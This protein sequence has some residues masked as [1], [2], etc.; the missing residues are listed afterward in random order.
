[1]CHVFSISLGLSG[2]S[3]LIYDCIYLQ[4]GKISGR[5]RFHAGLWNQEKGTGIAIF[6]LL[7]WMWISDKSLFFFSIIIVALI[8]PVSRKRLF[9]LILLGVER[10]PKGKEVVRRWVICT[11]IIWWMLVIMYHYICHSRLHRL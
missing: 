11:F 7:I 10:T 5:R 3:L 8:S 1:M 9:S 2:H 4:T 6:I